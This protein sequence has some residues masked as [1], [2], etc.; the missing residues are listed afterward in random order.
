VLKLKEAKFEK[1]SDP[2]FNGIVGQDIS[3]DYEFQNRRIW[4]YPPGS[5]K[6]LLVQDAGFGEE[7]SNAKGTP[8]IPVYWVDKWNFIFPY[9]PVTKNKA[10]FIL[11]NSK[12]GEQIKLGEVADIPRGDEPGYFTR[13]P[14]GNL[15]YVC[16]KGKELI[17][18]KSKSVKTLE[19]FHC[20]NKFDAQVVA[21]A[22][23]RII[24][25]KGAEIGKFHCDL[26]SIKD[27]KAAVA[28]EKKMKIEKEV[29]SQGIGV[30]NVHTK[31][32]STLM[33]DNVAAVLGWVEE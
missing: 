14:D 8:V 1:I 6:K 20:G 4:L 33:V 25:Y 16:P 9:Y 27:C 30:W 15:L 32:W 7:L 29:Y 23:G 28:L 10:T 13:D 24:K 11:V 2:V 31:K 3:V 18:V 19:Y 12:N 22:T 26:K 17:D 5:E 21:G